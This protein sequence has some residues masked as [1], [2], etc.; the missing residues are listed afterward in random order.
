MR[1]SQTTGARAPSV[2][3]RD[4]QALVAIGDADFAVLLPDHRQRVE[5]HAA[6]SACM[7]GNPP[8]PAGSR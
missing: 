4:L 5:R 3:E 8:A 1:N 2:V 6:V 7:R